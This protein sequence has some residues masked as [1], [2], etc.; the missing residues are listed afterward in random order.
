M[1]LEIIFIIKNK[2]ALFHLDGFLSVRLANFNNIYNTNEG[3]VEVYHHG[4]WGTVC[5]RS[6]DLNAASVVCR[7]MGFQGAIATRNYAYYGEGRGRIHLNSIDCTG[8]ETVLG[9]CKHDEGNGGGCTHAH[10]A[11]VICIGSA[12]KC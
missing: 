12:G 1:C 2:T 8:H 3:R 11:G 9:D 5:G 4:S 6:F 7:Q 10:D